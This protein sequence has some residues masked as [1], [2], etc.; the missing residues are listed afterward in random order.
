[1]TADSM[2]A[3]KV[4]GVIDLP[5]A[6]P[7]LGELDA[8]GDDGVATLTPPRAKRGLRRRIWL[9]R[10]LA[11]L[12]LA[13]V[14]TAWTLCAP[15]AIDGLSVELLPFIAAGLIVP[16]R[17]TR[18]ASSW[19]PA[20]TVSLSAA[21]LSLTAIEVSRHLGYPPIDVVV[22][23]WQHEVLTWGLVLA[24]VAI[25][26]Q[27]GQV[28]RHAADLRRLERRDP[29]TGVS[30][31]R[32]WADE[33]GR[34]ME[35]A[36]AEGSPLSV[37]V[38]DLD[39]FDSFNVV[40]G[41][42]AGDALLKRTALAW[43]TALR[44]GDVIA[45]HDGD[46]FTVLLPSCPMST[47]ATIVDRLRIAVA[48]EPTASAG[49]AAYEEGET[50]DS[51][52]ERV[53]AALRAA[54]LEGRDRTYV[55]DSTTLLAAGGISW[56]NVVVDALAER[57]I[58]A[59]YQPIVELAGSTIVAY[60]ALARPG[61]DDADLRVDEMFAAAQRM[62]LGRDLDWLCRHAAL[63]GSAW[64]PEG[65]PVFVNCSLSG[66]LDPQ[67]P[68]DQMTLMTRSANRSPE[69]VVLEITE[70]ELPG[71]LNRLRWV[72]STYRNEGF[73]IAIDD[74]GEGHNNLGVL[75]AT[76]PDYIK[77]A[78]PLV[79]DVSAEGPRA[80]IRAI[81]AFAAETGALVI[82]EGVDDEETIDILRHL[83]VHYAQ[84]FYFGRPAIPSLPARAEQPER[85]VRRRRASAIGTQRLAT[86]AASTR[87]GSRRPAAR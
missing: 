80:A 58:V 25:L 11:V 48:D 50:A 67:R 79:E 53:H 84:G 43:R 13:S 57:S 38:L 24:I 63:A 4:A 86:G 42:A 34:A 10:S 12:V 64:I 54:K 33:L 72:V 15:R 78:R 69:D 32:G 65:I 76:V 55:A 66:L 20:L 17:R 44:T 45:R 14:V 68:V 6:L 29:L 70:R 62:G 18:V 87:G 27:R 3:V 8:A 21:A 73:R 61:R 1:M 56:P 39:R 9:N 52:M 71:D 40:R 2:A 41:H 7:S 36:R 31:P 28:R 49:V 26:V 51:L 47:A 19:A 77:I 37:A 82:A 16:F 46:L 22:G 85:P 30:N 81:V 75:A 74:L 35:R 59:A 23:A 83:G 5:G 60:E